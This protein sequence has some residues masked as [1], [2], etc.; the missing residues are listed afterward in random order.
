MGLHDRYLIRSPHTLT[1]P[2][3]DGLVG[4]I[5]AIGRA[6][7]PWPQVKIVDCGGQ[8]LGSF[9]TKAGVE[10]ASSVVCVALHGFL[11]SAL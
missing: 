8:L 9:L 5:G 2:G 6:P 11:P 4:W 3:I 10:L 1:F 7:P